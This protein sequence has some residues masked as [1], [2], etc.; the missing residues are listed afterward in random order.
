MPLG[1]CGA[2]RRPIDL[3]PSA[4]AGLTWPSTAPASDERPRLTHAPMRTLTGEAAVEMLR[5][6]VGLK[7]PWSAS[8]AL[9]V[10]ACFPSR[11]V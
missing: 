8:A 6:C 11:L 7:Q 3:M 4:A 5:A 10:A 9:V 1:A 2:D